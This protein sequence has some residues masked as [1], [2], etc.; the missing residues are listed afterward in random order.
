MFEKTKSTLMVLAVM[1]M[2]MRFANAVSPALFVASPLPTSSQTLLR[3]EREAQ[4][5]P[6]V[7]QLR[8]LR[9]DPTLSYYL[10]VPKQLKTGT[11]TFVT[12]HG[13][14]RRAHEHA[15]LFAPFAE[16]QGVVLI[17]P[18]FSANRFPDY[19][20]MSR[21]GRGERS[22]QA[23]ETIVAEVGRLTRAD[24]SKLYLFGY[25]GGAQFVHRFAMA[26]PE[27]VARYVLGAAGWYTFPDQTIKYPLGIRAAKKLPGVTF[28][29]N[30]FLAV[31][32]MVLVGER[33]NKQN[34]DM[35]DSSK[36][37]ALQGRSRL[38]RGQK[39]VEVMQQRAREHGFATHYEFAVLP[40]S[41]HMFRQCM[42]RGNMGR[43]TF[44]F[45]FEKAST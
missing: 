39:W 33:D 4:L 26:H 1:V 34:G 43:M 28:D 32:A 19:Q 6:G 17:A 45:L 8:T 2:S 40:R 44:G 21:I 10:Y 9:S 25:S 38:E 14:S 16:A 13:I 5:T 18:Y 27:R 42:K 35:R 41:R 30:R 15:A 37:D 24:T 22:D 31:P 12:V 29:P 11:R 7:V 36:L 20:R 3:I 23:L